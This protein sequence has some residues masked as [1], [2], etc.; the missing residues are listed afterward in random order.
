MKPLDGG[1]ESC[2]MGDLTE[3]ESGCESGLY[4]RGDELLL[5]GLRKES[6]EYLMTPHEGA[7]EHINASFLEE[8][9]FEAHE[10]PK[11]WL[12][13]IRIETLLEKE[14]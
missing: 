7:P 13:Q 10:A 9:A 2:L 11:L 3:N 8:L 5:L 12:L 4:T 14:P 1:I 6:H